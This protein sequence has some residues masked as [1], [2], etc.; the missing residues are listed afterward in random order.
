MAPRWLQ[1][2]LEGSLVHWSRSGLWF[3]GFVR[4]CKTIWIEQDDKSSP[5]PCSLI[6]EGSYLLRQ[7]DPDSCNCTDQSGWRRQENNH[8]GGPEHQGCVGVEFGRELRGVH[9]HGS[10]TQFDAPDPQD[11][12]GDP[13]EAP[14]PNRCY[15]SSSIPTISGT[16]AT[17]ELADS[18]NGDGEKIGEVQTRRSPLPLMPPKDPH[19]QLLSMTL[20]GMMTKMP[21]SF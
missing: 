2:M 8:H 12:D 1:K 18:S 11:A 5:R 6:R 15:Q 16:I 3:H 13:Q 19:L 21:P 17:G 14:G 10:S 4:V 7:D 9:F 20:L